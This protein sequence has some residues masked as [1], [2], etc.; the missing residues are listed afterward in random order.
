MVSPLVPQTAPVLAARARPPAGRED[1]PPRVPSRASWYTAP[2]RRPSKGL[3]EGFPC[4]KVWAMSGAGDRTGRDIGTYFLKKYFRY[5][6]YTFSTSKL[7][8]H[9]DLGLDRAQLSGFSHSCCKS[10]MYLG[11]HGSLCTMGPSPL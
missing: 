2:S 5:L 9:A 11:Q 8:L 10:S 4:R 6:Y 3:T 7:C 1:R